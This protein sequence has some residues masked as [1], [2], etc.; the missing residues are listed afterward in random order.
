MSKF[1]DLTGQRFGRLIVIKQVG[2]NKWGR[3]NWLCL[4][5]CGRE[6]LVCTGDLNIGRTKSCGCLRKE[7]CDIANTTHGY[8]KEKIYKI[9]AAMIQR[10]TN[11][12]N[13][14]WKDY[15]GR[16]IMVCERWIKPENFIKDMIKKWKPGLTLE[17]RNNDKGYFPENCYWATWE[18]QQRNT[19]KNHLITCFG[20]T[21][22]IAAW[23][24]ETGIPTKIISWRIDRGWTPNRAL[25][26]PV[27]KYKKRKK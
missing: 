23:S 14:Q 27:K 13:K 11:P 17:R 20:K 15:G 1:I 22:C 9:W 7:K 25:T 26:I 4:C 3:T 24:E 16:E 2:K 12:N 6:T 5:E 19:R 18:E 10:C 8:S 21:Q